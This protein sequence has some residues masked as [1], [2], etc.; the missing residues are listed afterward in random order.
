MA[1]KPEPQKRYICSVSGCAAAY[2][3]QWKLDAHL[4]K[5]TGVKP[6]T[7]GQDGCR[8]SFCSSY[9]LTRHE[10]TH[11]GVKPFQCTE[12][13]CKEAFTT[14]TNR[15]RHVTRV[16]T[17]EHKKYEC[18][19]EGCGLEFK[20]KELL[21]S[22]MCEQH[23]LLPPY[24]CT[25][26]GCE[27]RFTVPSKLKRHEKVHQGYPCKE[28]GCSFTGKTWTEYLK[29]RK[30]QHRPTLKCE[31]CNKEFKD[32]WFLQ[33]HQYVHSET[34]VVLKCP[35]EACDR[36]FTKM[37]NL[38]SHISSFHEEE[39]PFTCPHAGCGKT[40]A[41]K[42][43][44]QRHNIAH[45]PQRK[46]IQRQQAK[47]SLASRLSGL[48]D[49]KRLVY[50]KTRQAERKPAQTP[51]DPPGPVELVCLLQDTSLLCSA[52]VDTQGLTDALTSPLTV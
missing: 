3:K 14:N 30:E 1:T 31:Q 49:T 27:M 32:S 44:L 40:F 5:H 16:H 41:M 11:T 13:G 2:N 36:S 12:D 48:S 19:Y 17:Q 43:S 51:S 23:T 35:R 21:K 46:K 52:A 39:R 47:R 15:A 9:H 26:E 25:H 18:K 8:K 34:R 22:H 6:H 50:K 45:D 20:K 28:E 37:F 4:C 24:K 29:H 7:C 38:Q 10:L 33:Q 42:Q